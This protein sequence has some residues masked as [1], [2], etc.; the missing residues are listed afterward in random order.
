MNSAKA[1]LV[2]IAA[3]SLLAGSA[4]A[5][6]VVNPSL[7]TGPAPG[8]AIPLPVGST[9]ITGW[10]VTRNAIDYVGDRWNASQ[11]VRS[12]GLNGS[13]AGG[14]GQTLTTTPGSVYTVSFF[15]GGD[16]FA[17][18]LLKHMRVAAAGQFQDYEF[19]A[20]HA[21]PWGMGYL[22]KTFVF[23][24]SATST[25]LEFYSLDGG[26]STGPVLDQVSVTG[27]SADTPP[28]IRAFALAAP[29]PNPASREMAVTFEVPRRAPVRVTVLD[30]QGREVAVLANGVLDAGPYVRTWGGSGSPSGPAG[31]Y[32]V[33]LQSPGVS[34][35]RK[36][37][38]AR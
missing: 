36:A 8:M 4:R 11:G 9:A 15:M 30:L 13:T 2:S 37:V 25:F 16:A 10:T 12:V 34:L 29:R 1:F 38:F 22:E 19:D 5:N 23:T 28:S 6:M 24:A 27:P 17:P 21:W 3:L 32:L 18:T 20:S 31:V 26:D 35:V 7:E 14:I 33:R